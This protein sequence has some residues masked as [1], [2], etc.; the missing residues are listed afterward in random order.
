MF[1]GKHTNVQRKKKKK[2]TSIGNSQKAKYKKSLK[3]SRTL[4]WQHMTMETL[5]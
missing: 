3:I 1:P 4:K 2:H 5:K